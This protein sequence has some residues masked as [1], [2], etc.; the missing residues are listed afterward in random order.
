MRGAACSSVALSYL[1]HLILAPGDL[2]DSIPVP[3][4]VPVGCPRRAPLFSHRRHT[5]AAHAFVFCWC[6]HLR[7]FVGIQWAS[8]PRRHLRMQA[9]ASAGFVVLL[10]GCAATS[11]ALPFLAYLLSTPSLRR[12]FQLPFP[13][14]RIFPTFALPAKD[15][16]IHVLMRDR[17][18]FPSSRPARAWER[19]PWWWFE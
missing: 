10:V 16:F 2:G 3:P 15:R 11:H 17:P 14:R 1:S 6:R 13:R 9:S 4:L 5:Q 19:I 18:A 12:R 7:L 8:T